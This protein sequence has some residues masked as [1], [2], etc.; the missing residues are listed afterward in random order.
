MLSGEEK[1]KLVL[2]STPTEEML[3]QDKCEESRSSG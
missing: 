3:R 2:T 1:A